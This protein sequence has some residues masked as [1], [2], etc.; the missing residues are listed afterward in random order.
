MILCLGYR[1]HSFSRVLLKQQW[2]RVVST[3]H[4]RGGMG[5]GRDRKDSGFS[6][7]FSFREKVSGSV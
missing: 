6:L 2:F 7:S 1:E 3:E 5:Q 4:R